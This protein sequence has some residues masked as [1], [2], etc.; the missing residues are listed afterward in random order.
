MTM[1][2][3]FTEI[4]AAAE[5]ADANYL[6]SLTGCQGPESQ[7]RINST[8]VAFSQ[9]CNIK[10]SSTITSGYGFNARLLGPTATGTVEPKEE[11]IMS[12]YETEHGAA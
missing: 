5:S 2:I 4:K 6:S 12:S 10:S 7:G 1:A 11:E 9:T 3:T 8:L